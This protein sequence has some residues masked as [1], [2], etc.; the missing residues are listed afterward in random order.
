MDDERSSYKSAKKDAETQTVNDHLYDHAL[1]IVNNFETI[2][3]HCIRVQR[4][5]QLLVLG[6]AVS[7]I[8]VIHTVKKHGF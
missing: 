3:Q 7:V 6:I 8:T 5:N 1:S 4:I 2:S